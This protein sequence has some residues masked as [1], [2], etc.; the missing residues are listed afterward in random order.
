MRKKSKKPLK[1]GSV[2][3]DKRMPHKGSV[4]T[5]HYLLL[6]FPMAL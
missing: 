3:L 2:S 5:E 4:R 1:E 6:G